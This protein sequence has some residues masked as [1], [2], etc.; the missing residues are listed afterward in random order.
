MY[1]N[2]IRKPLNFFKRQEGGLERGIQ[3]GEFDQSKLYAL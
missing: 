3:K 1:E 2:R